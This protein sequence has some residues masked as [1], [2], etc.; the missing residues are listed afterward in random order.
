MPSKTPKKSL[1]TALEAP[2]AA[3]RRGVLCGVHRILQQMPEAERNAVLSRLQD[4]R[5]ERKRIGSNGST[6][7]T[8]RW[9]SQVLNENGYAVSAMVVQNHVRK[10]C[11]C[12]Y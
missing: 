12:G 4:I 5:E 7:I 6:G 3:S 8:A 1:I 2:P 10:S 9:L 11:S